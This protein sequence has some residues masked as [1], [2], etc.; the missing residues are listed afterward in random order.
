MGLGGGGE[1]NDRG[2]GRVPNEDRSGIGKQGIDFGNGLDDGK[3]GKLDDIEDEWKEEELVSGLQSTKIRRIEGCVPR[4]TPKERTRL[5][6][7]RRKKHG[8]IRR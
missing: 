7:L 3:S 2:Y 5:K 6:C 1:G 8:W 4:Q